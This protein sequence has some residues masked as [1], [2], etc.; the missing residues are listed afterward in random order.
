MPHA[1]YQVVK[2]SLLE[3]QCAPYNVSRFKQLAA[4]ELNTQVS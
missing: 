1:M 2:H 4:Q 3:A